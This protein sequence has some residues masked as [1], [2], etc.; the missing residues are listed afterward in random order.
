MGK[1]RR[2]V[3]KL[4]RPLVGSVPPRLR[5]RRLHAYGVGL[6]KTG[7][8][9]LAGMFERSYRS[10]HEPDRALLLRT[11]VA[12]VEGR[13]TERD[14]VALIRQRDARRRL[15]M[16]SS[17][18]NAFYLDVLVRQ[19]P[20]A[21]FV[22][23]IRD[24]YSWLD[25]LL[26]EVVHG[27]RPFRDTPVFR[28][29]I[30]AWA[31]PHQY[32]H[33]DGERGLLAKHGLFPLSCYLDLWTRQNRRI[34]RTVPKKRLLVVRTDRITASVPRI[35][36]F[37]GVPERN[38]DGRR[39]H[40]NRGRKKRG[41]LDAMDRRFVGREIAGRCGDLVERYFPDAALVSSRPGK[42]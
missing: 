13:I 20:S 4:V 40:L 32:S 36:E 14:R 28:T 21:K 34:L 37:L 33:A 3:G 24:P 9:S 7:T 25:S 23:L 5:R 31:R 29:F 2:G 10:A 16:D 1:V 35:A 12:A 26:Q 11:H 8:T 38:L 15:E 19:F 30:Q 27:H 18:H 17:Q 42:K 39:T 6:P 41:L 22:M